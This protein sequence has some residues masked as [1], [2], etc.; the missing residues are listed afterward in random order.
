MEKAIRAGE[1]RQKGM[2]IDSGSRG[3]REIFK[4]NS[5]KL[6]EISCK[7]ETNTLKCPLQRAIKADS[8]KIGQH[9]ETIA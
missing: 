8:E 9:I 1:G 7:L 6:I 3:K 5:F 2:N 4:D